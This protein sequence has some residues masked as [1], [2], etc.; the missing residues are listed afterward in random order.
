MKVK[1]NYLS[2]TVDVLIV[3]TMTLLCVITL[4]PFIYCL[5][6]SLSNY[7]AAMTHNITVYPIGFTFDNYAIVFQNQQLFTAFLVSVARTVIGTAY[8]L[9]VT[10]LA[11]YAISK[12]DIPG[13]RFIAL[14]LIIPM[15]INGGLMPNYVNIYKLGLFNNFLVYIL[16]LGFYTYFMLVMRTYFDSLPPSLEESAKLDGASDIAIFFK[17]ILPLSAPIIA[18]VALF[19]GV[20]QWNSWFDAMLYVTKRDLHPLQTVLQRILQQ[21]ATGDMQAAAKA[22]EFKKQTSP[23]ALQ[24]AMLIITTVPI[25]CVY[26]FLQRFFIKGIL[27]G[28]VKA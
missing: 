26:P 6:Y 10:G 15:Y 8:C 9:F 22:A 23:E 17:I 27:I 19:A 13:N 1:R 5:A 4:Y 20:N 28:A 11:A 2:N 24:M 12:R 14:V 16:P 3:I 7:L 21:N 18:T 25:V